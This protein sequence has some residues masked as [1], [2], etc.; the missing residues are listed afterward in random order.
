VPLHFAH[1]RLGPDLTVYVH[2]ALEGRKAE[3]IGPGA[4][5]CFEADRRIGL[6]DADS[7]CGIGAEYE[8]V[9]G[10]GRVAPCADRLEAR[11]GLVALLDKYA[12]GRSDQL[13]EEIGRV[14]VWRMVLEE[15]TAKRRTMA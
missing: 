14:M 3:A 5:A 8:S 2:G 13:P 1:V 10:W 9:I 12:P 7:P 15:V 6:V 4:W 11:A